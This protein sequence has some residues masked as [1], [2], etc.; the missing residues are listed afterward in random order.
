VASNG[1]RL[2]ALF[3]VVSATS[4]S[5]LTHPDRFANILFDKGNGS[6]NLLR[7]EGPGMDAQGR[8]NHR[9]AISA[10]YLESPF[11]GFTI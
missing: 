7:F 1:K 4:C 6:L 11:V 9:I 10:G 3:V 2:R 5:D 8:I